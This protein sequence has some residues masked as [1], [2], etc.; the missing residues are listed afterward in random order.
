MSQPVS[1]NEIRGISR[2]PANRSIDRDP[3][4]KSLSRTPMGRKARV[5][6]RARISLSGLR[7]R[8]RSQPARNWPPYLFFAWETLSS[9]L[10]L[11]DRKAR[12]VILELVLEARRCVTGQNKR[13]ADIARIRTY[14]RIRT[15]CSRIPKCIKRGPKALSRDLN[16]A[17]L[18]LTKKRIDVEVLESILETARRTF[19]A[20]PDSEP[21]RAALESLK[22]VHFSGLPA[23]SQDNVRKA[24]ARFK[25][26]KNAN[27]TAE[28]LFIAIGA[29]ASER[30]WR[31]DKHSNQRPHRELRFRTS[32]NMGT[33][34]AEP[35]NNQS[36][37][38][39]GS[40][41]H[42]I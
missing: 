5:N 37:S 24:V 29:A 6:F 35:E 39:S 12:F 1:K 25:A 15:A 3:H 34:R 28:H 31:Q 17:L 41:S 21:S 2:H 40:K 30:E 27:R 18:P 7:I 38:V 33:G 19:E 42:N 32:S 11:S 13:L 4:S 20:F 26:A 14:R 16:Q 36:S 22:G 23:T 9:E 10:G 8:I